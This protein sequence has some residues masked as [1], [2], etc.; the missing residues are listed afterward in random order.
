MADK[1]IIVK[2]NWEL[3]GEIILYIFALVCFVYSGR[4]LM[5][6]QTDVLEAVRSIKW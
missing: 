1:K 4:F 2:F 5:S 6:H 3:I